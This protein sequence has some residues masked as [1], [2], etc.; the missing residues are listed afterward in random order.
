MGILAVFLP[1]EQIL[2]PGLIWLCMCSFPNKHVKKCVFVEGEGQT[3]CEAGQG[4]V[5]FILLTHCFVE[6][7]GR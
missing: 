3:L 4:P 7:T 1:H 2:F 5:T 6:Q